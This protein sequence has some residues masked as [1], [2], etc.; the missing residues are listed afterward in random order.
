MHPAPVPSSSDPSLAE[1]KLCVKLMP[2]LSL[3]SSNRIAGFAVAPGCGGV[4]L[5]AERLL[6]CAAATHPANNQK[7]SE[8]RNISVAS[9]LQL[10]S[11]S[12]IDRRR[13]AQ[14]HLRHVVLR[15]TLRP[16]VTPNAIALLAFANP[17]PAM[18]LPQTR[19]FR[20]QQNE[21]NRA[22]RR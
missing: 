2:A 3:A 4:P 12:Q 13:R 9:P 1:P 21:T 14:Q 15:R 18:L 22:I 10:R 5:V 11:T 17:E 20:I 19:A 7:R 16:R 6:I 8:R